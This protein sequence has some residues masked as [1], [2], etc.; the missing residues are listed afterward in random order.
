MQEVLSDVMIINTH[1]LF[2]R[3]FT[4]DDADFI[5]ALLNSP[6]W[7]QFIGDRGVKT[8]EDARRF[9]SEKYIP[10][11][12]TNGFGLY[13]VILKEGNI[14]VGMCG[15]IKRETL[16]DIDIGFAFL[17]E[18]ISKGYG[19]EAATAV[20]KYGLDVLKI[21]RIVAITIPTNL[22]SINLLKKLGMK[23]EKTFFMQGDKDELMLFGST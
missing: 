11:Y 18:Y 1:R 2:L 23:F 16:E 17:P 9:I 14:P 20:L 6:A 7:L 4:E 5:V 15:L 22:S 3:E 21:K 12:R 13:A 19:F 8:S 10:S